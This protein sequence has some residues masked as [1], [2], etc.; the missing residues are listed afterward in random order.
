MPGWRRR[1][2]AGTPHPAYVEATLGGGGQLN[3]ILLWATQ[4]FHFGEEGPRLAAPA[5][6]LEG[7]SGDQECVFLSFQSLRDDASLDIEVTPNGHG[8]FRL[9]VACASMGLAGD[10]LQDLCAYLQVRPLARHD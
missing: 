4:R 8:G 3:R 6:A 7:H 2:A 10:V 1:L 9:V 5:E